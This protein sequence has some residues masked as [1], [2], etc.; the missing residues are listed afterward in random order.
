MTE[1][2]KILKNEQEID[3][4]METFFCAANR[5]LKKVLSL[6][7]NKEG[8][9]EEVVFLSF[10]NDLDDYDMAQLPK[11][12]DDK[13]VLIELASPAVEV[14]QV[15]Y[16][17]FDTFYNYLDKNVKKETKKSDDS[18]LIELLKRVKIT[19]EI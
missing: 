7:S 1:E 15:V 9:G 12:L 14:N 11:P 5:N 18:E 19:L 17:D 16:L 4:L 2:F 13:H 8:W 3:C 10:E 6:L